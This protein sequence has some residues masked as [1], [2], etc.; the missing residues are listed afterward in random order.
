MKSNEL[1][2]MEENIKSGVLRKF[3]LLGVTMSNIQ[4]EESKT[5]P[6]AATDGA[7]LYYNPEFIKSLS[8]NE[9]IFAFAHE[10]MHVAFDH[11]LRSKN[12]DKRR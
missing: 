12:K 3:P 8:S 4:V 11:I 9:R 10:Y 2:Q 5:L 7:K 6:T 1:K